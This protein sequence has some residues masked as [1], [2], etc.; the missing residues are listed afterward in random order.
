MVCRTASL[1][2]PK[3]TNVIKEHV[4]LLGLCWTVSR[5]FGRVFHQA[6]VLVF[7]SDAQ[8]SVPQHEDPMLKGCKGRMNEGVSEWLSA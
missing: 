7:A 2:L 5:C 4:L 6:N 8:C 3:D 1:Q